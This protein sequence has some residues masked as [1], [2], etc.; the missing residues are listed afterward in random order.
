MTRLFLVAYAFVILHRKL[1]TRRFG[2]ME[3][4]G[5]QV[6]KLP[7]TRPPMGAF[8]AAT[9]VHA[10]VRASTIPLASGS[11]SAR[12]RA[13]ARPCATPF[14]RSQLSS[15]IH[16]LLRHG[17]RVPCMR[18]QP[19]VQPCACPCARPWSCARASRPRPI[20]PPVRSSI[21]LSVCPSVEGKSGGTKV[22]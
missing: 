8:A 16:P 2:S 9:A 7:W 19:S 18:H 5:H 12:F 20:R 11:V 3:L 17:D 22:S 14:N 1:P 4:G 6:G 10:C 21:R 15:C 13:H